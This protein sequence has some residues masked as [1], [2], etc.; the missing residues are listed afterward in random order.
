MLWPRLLPLAALPDQGIGIPCDVFD[1]DQDDDDGEE[2]DNDGEFKFLREE[3]LQPEFPFCLSF[4]SFA[5][6]I[7]RLSQVKLTIIENISQPFERN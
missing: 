2:E 1:K 4:A 6:K 5:K 3:K 7:F